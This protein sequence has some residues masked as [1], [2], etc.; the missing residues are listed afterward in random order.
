[1]SVNYAN[2][3]LQGLNTNASRLII[4]EN[5]LIDCNNV[6]VDQTGIIGT[7]RGQEFFGNALTSISKIFGALSKVFAQADD[8]LYYESGGTFTEV[9]FPDTESFT[10]ITDTKIDTLE[11]NKSLFFTGRRTES[12]ST[13]LVQDDQIKKLT[14]T[15][16]DVVNAGLDAPFNLSITTFPGS[17]FPINTAFA[18][19]VFYQYRD[20]N[21]YTITSA[22]SSRAIAL[23]DSGAACE[24]LLTF[25]IPIQYNPA[26]VKVY[27]AI[28]NDVLSPVTPDDNLFWG[29]ETVISNAQSLNEPLNSTLTFSNFILRSQIQNPIDLYTN[30]T[31][32]GI[33]QNNDI[34]LSALDIESYSGFTFYSNLSG[35]GEKL[36]IIQELPLGVTITVSGG[37]SYRRAATSDYSASP[38]LFSGATTYEAAL[39]FARAV[40]ATNSVN[41][42]QLVP[43]DYSN[44]GDEV[45]WV[46]LTSPTAATEFGSMNSVVDA[47]GN[48]YAIL[49]NAGTSKFARYNPT[50]NTWAILRDPPG[51]CTYSC[52]AYSSARNTVVSVFGIDG[53]SAQ[54]PTY[55]YDIINDTWATGTSPPARAGIVAL[56]KAASA[57]FIDTI[58]IMCGENTGGTDY[59]YAW[60]YNMA[61]DSWNVSIADVPTIG[62]VGRRSPCGSGL[63]LVGNIFMFGGIDSGSGV[64]SATAFKYNI[65]TA[66]WSSITALPAARSAAGACSVSDTVYVINGLDAGLSDTDTVYA[67][68]VTTN[69]YTTL[70]VTNTAEAPIQA[71]SADA[72]IYRLGNVDFES[73]RV[74]NIPI[75]FE[76]KY[77]TRSSNPGFT[78]TA[79]FLPFG[80]PSNSIS[81]TKPLY[82]S[83]IQYSKQGQPEAVPFL[84]NFFVGSASYPIKRIAALRTSLLVLKTDGI[85]QL[86]GVSPETF[87][88]S[89]LDPTFVLLASQSV[90]K[91]NNEIYCLSNKGIVSINESGPKILSYK[92][93]DLIDSALATVPQA[94]WDTAITAAAYEDDYKYVITIGS[95]TF[96]YNYITDQ[97]TIWH[98]GNSSITS[99]TLFN[100]YLY[101]SDVTRVLKERKTLTS[102]DFQDENGAG[103]ECFIQFNNL[104]FMLGQVI[105]L[106]A[107]Q[108]QQREISGLTSEVTF[109]NDFNTPVANEFLLSKYI[110]RTLPPPAGRMAFW[111]RP[112]ISWDTELASPGGTFS[113]LKL[114]GIDFEYTTAQSNI[115]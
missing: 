69:T 46:D 53:A 92:I 35:R 71:V 85:F 42:A 114:E 56:N 65:N 7:R 27:Y 103:L 99:W 58:Y 70:T 13:A 26:E 86:N 60:E 11:A 61:A 41:R 6:V 90:A 95:K 97:W 2:I 81:V 45:G 24:F 39:D 33:L 16:S 98:A 64:A 44:M 30:S 17:T 32:E 21:L 102:L 76:E 107:M 91:L 78:T 54:C 18:I 115:K 25:Q 5:N 88:L 62:A 49:E 38:V 87:S 23:N 8:T 59:P 105:T 83:M 15:S 47:N 57:V 74:G 19:R 72:S 48:I 106:N 75:N 104:E 89:Q 73:Y 14:S 96:T 10:A 9:N 93:K 112:K 22:V 40:T 109:I 55:I 52:L 77:I 50:T 36:G 31:Q 110:C 84:N 43:G 3:N 66:S 12:T 34:P 100:N 94:N 37:E 79:Y 20:S 1:M 80:Y 51:R 68:N 111:F 28:S 67:Y 63:L 82:P 101:Y 108:L 113:D 29:A 4:D